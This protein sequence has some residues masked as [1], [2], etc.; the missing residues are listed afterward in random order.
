MGLIGG[1]KKM[2]P[3]SEDEYDYANESSGGD[4]HEDSNA[5]SSI[6]PH[7]SEEESSS[8]HEKCEEEVARDIMGV[9]KGRAVRVIESEE[10][11]DEPTFE[12]KNIVEKKG[13]KSK[14]N[15]SE[16]VTQSKAKRKE[17]EKAAAF[18]SKEMITD[19]DDE[20]IDAS[21]AHG[22]SKV[23]IIA[24]NEDIDKSRKKA[25]SREKDVETHVKSAKIKDKAGAP[26][27][28]VSSPDEERIKKLK[29]SLYFGSRG[30][31]RLLVLIE[32]WRP[33]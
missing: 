32:I 12:S 9:N 19:S 8:E 7:G 28:I 20:D 22:E 6:P 2:E 21:M 27:K 4:V 30:A 11:E 23:T 24:D 31:T 17:E 10:E 18:K 25:K 29:V 5:E 15:K 1:S 13:G 3:A 26:S 14:S 16:P 33:Y